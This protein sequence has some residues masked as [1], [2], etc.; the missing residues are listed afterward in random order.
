MYPLTSVKTLNSLGDLLADCCLLFEERALLFWFFSMTLLGCVPVESPAETGSNVK[1]A[2]ESRT[3]WERL[4]RKLDLLKRGI[5]L[6]A[7][8][9]YLGIA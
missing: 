5:M 8:S 9:S 3:K 4:K 7:F 6:S 1:S 2:V